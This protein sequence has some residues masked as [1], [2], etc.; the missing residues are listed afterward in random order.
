MGLDI[1]RNQIKNILINEYSFDQL[2]KEFD[3]KYM[4][5]EKYNF[6]YKI[7]QK[8]KKLKLETAI[9]LALFKYEDKFYTTTEIS[10]IINEEILENSLK[11]KDNISRYFNQRFYPYY[12]V[13]YEEEKQIS[14]YKI[15]YTGISQIKYLLEH[16]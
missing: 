7:T 5:I 3:T 1:I 15:N 8:Y 4:H 6:K 11:H 2:Y 12:D 13:E 16:M 9:L 14:K 10:K